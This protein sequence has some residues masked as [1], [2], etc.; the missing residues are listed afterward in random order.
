MTYLSLKQEKSRCGHIESPRLNLETPLI[1]LHFQLKGQL[2][3]ML[4]ANMSNNIDRVQ[5][6]P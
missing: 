4:Y 3:A 1:Q 5:H 2:V 6:R